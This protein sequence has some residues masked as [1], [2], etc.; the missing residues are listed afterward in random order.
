M[1]LSMV[2]LDREGSWGLQ[3]LD[4]L[5]FPGGMGCEGG[6]GGETGKG[7]GSEWSLRLVR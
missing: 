6:L 2:S 1:A 3:S 4:T 5:T 7:T